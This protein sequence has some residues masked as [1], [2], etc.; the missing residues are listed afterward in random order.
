MP[1]YK[2]FTQAEFSETV[3]RFL[4]LP[5][6]CCQTKVGESL[7]QH[8]LQLDSYGDNLMSATN[9]PGDSFRIRHDTIKTVL[10]SFCMTSGIRAECEVYGLFKHL[11]PTQALEDEGCLERGRGRQGLLPDFKLEVPSPDGEP[12]ERLAELKV[13]GAVSKWYPRNGVQAR[14]KKAVQRRATGLPNEYRNPLIKLDA[15]YHGTSA[16]RKG[17]LLRR[18]EGYGDLICLVVGSF[19]EGSRDLHALLEWMTD[20]KMRSIGLARGWE[21]SDHERSMILL[22]LRRELS[23]AAAKANS[24]CLISRVAKIGNGHRQAAKRRVWAK[25]EEE[26]RIEEA[27]CHWLAN[28]RGRG[29]FRELGE[30]ITK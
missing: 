4:C 20:A 3:A 18:L 30:F 21:G 19:Q 15:K 26:K 25:R 22:N 12:T 28:I 7:G 17:P 16:D 10:N 13:I 1:G 29:I 14:K 27:K 11:I 8:G 6:P 2:G 9:I 5:S 23:T 24:R